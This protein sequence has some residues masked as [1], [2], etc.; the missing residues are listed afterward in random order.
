MCEKDTPMKMLIFS[1]F[2]NSLFSITGILSK[3]NL[4]YAMI[5]GLVLQLIKRLL[6]LNQ[7]KEPTKL[8]Y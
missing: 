4:K 7:H 3:Y 8:M 1:D 6:I 2:G 5:K